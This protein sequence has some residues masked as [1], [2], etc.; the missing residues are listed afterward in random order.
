MQPWNFRVFLKDMPMRRK[1]YLLDTR[2]MPSYTTQNSRFRSMCVKDV[3]S[4]TQEMFIQLEESNDIIDG[5][6]FPY[7]P[8]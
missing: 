8:S 5:A 7:Y 1:E 4:M 6:D 2:K 3:V